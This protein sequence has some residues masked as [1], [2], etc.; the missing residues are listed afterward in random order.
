MISL[1]RLLDRNEA[2]SAPSFLRA[3]SLLMEAIAIH[4]VQSDP[5]VYAGFRDAVRG[6]RRSTEN[7]ESADQVLVSTGQVIQAMESYNREIETFARVQAAEFQEMVRMLSRTLLDITRESAHAGENLSKIEK[8]LD[9]I[10]G[11]DDLRSIKSKLRD[12][13]QSIAKESSRQRDSARKVSE[14]LHARLRSVPSETGVVDSVTGLGSAAE[15]ERIIAEALGTESSVYVAV[16]CMERLNAINL[17]FGY[18]VGDRLML[19][20]AQDVAQRLSAADTLF[21]WRGPTLVAVMDRPVKIHD[22]RIE[23]SRFVGQRREQVVR[24]QERTVLLPVAA[25]TTVIS[26]KETTSLEEV[27]DRLSAFVASAA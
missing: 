13:L 9:A 17:S 1:K 22:V 14:G 2:E 6:Y 24:I 19:Q 26:L 3:C 15:A 7:P 20:F 8:D 5:L 27:I 18:A 23:V 21:R 10:A 25:R 12:S 11:L 16:L 4:A